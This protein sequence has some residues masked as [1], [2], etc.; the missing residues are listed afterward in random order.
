M[1][2]GASDVFRVISLLLQVKNEK[3]LHPASLARRFWSKRIGRDTRVEGGG[4]FGLA[5]TCW[6]TQE[7]SNDLELTNSTS[8]SSTRTSRTSSRLLRRDG[9]FSLSPRFLG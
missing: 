8:C 4:A 1:V 3:N 2:E 5:G 7:C 6:G 9:C